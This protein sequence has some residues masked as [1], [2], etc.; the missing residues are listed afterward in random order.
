M[1]TVSNTGSVR[2]GVV[3]VGALGKHHTRLYAESPLAELVGVTDVDIERA[4]QIAEEYG[5][6]VFSSVSELAERVDALSVAVPTTEH[7]EVV[8]DLLERGTHVLVEKPLATSAAEG[9]RLIEMADRAKVVLAVGHVERYNPVLACLDAVPGPPRFIAADRLASYP[10]ARPGLPPRGTEVSVIHDLMIHDL[11]VILSL[12]D[13]AVVRV[14]AV[15]IAIL[16]P[17][18]DIVNAR[19]VF[20]NET[21]ANLNASR[22]SRDRLRKIRV[23]KDTAY[24][25]L[26]YQAQKGEMATVKDGAVEHA[27]VP[28]GEGNALLCELEDFCR[29]VRATK[30]SGQVAQPRVCGRAGLRALALADRIAEACATT[31]HRSTEV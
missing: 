3:G 8:S 29:C 1:E 17:T 4:G 20:E 22:V 28:A 2:T 19:L 26:D 7:C 25:S 11:D 10:P 31:S 18:E 6:E 15:G 5:C 12:V 30:D 27:S 14:D 24:L 9:E 13:C 21:V 16:S 23:F